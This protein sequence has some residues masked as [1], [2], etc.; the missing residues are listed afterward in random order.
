MDRERRLYRGVPIWYDLSGNCGSH[1]YIEVDYA[2]ANGLSRRH[3]H[4]FP[5]LVM[6][7]QEIDGYYREKKLANGNSLA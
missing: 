4:Y 1:W 6:A 2:I 3:R 5:T 7:K